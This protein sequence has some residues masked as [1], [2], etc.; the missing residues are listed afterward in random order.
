MFCY[1]CVIL[2]TCTTGYHIYHINHYNCFLLFTPHPP[3]I[4]LLTHSYTNRGLDISRGYNPDMLSPEQMMNVSNQNH[5]M[6]T[7]RMTSATPTTQ[8]RVKG[9]N[10]LCAQNTLHA[11]GREWFSLIQNFRFFYYSAL[12]VATPLAISSPVRR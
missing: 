9:N 1:G 10:W 8:Q 7:P 6:A 3:S 5:Q 2:P 11:C 4:P 12:G